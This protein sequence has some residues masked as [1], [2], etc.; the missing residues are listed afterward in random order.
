MDHPWV[1]EDA[2]KLSLANTIK[3]SN[4]VTETPKT[5]STFARGNI[6]VQQAAKQIECVTR[7]LLAT[8]CAMK[9][10]N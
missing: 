7:L 1:S 10:A 9:N 5:E 2:E 4:M 8:W 3:V 6:S